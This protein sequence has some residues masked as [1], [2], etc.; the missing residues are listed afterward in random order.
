V[1][2]TPAIDS[3]P[4]RPAGD[5]IEP[6]PTPERI[7]EAARRV[8]ADPAARDAWAACRA[9]EEPDPR[10]LYALLGARRL[11]APAW[12]VAYGGRG[13]TAHHQAAVVDVLVEAGVPETLHTLSVQIAGTFLLGAGS[14]AQRATLLPGLAAGRSFCTVLY[15]EPDVGSDLAALTTTAEREPGGGWRLSGRKVYSVKTG[16]ADL[17][18][19]AARTPGGASRYQGITL[20]C[21]PLAT[22]GVTVGRLPSIGDE[23]FADVMF[24]GAVVPDGCVV[25]PVGEAWPLITDALALERTGVDYHAKARRWLALWRA[26]APAAGPP[27]AGAATS[28]RP[29]PS[30]V[31][32]AARLESRVRAAQLFATGCLDQMAAG[33]VDPVFAALTKLWCAETATSPGSAPRRPPPRC[34]RTRTPPSARRPA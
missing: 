4:R 34:R 16:L 26:G 7:G 27:A 12:P 20:F 21:V 5:G 2:A 29:E 25:G 13:L 8:L 33:R 15:S 1:T 32:D 9:G 22:P 3:G 31:V 18:L 10:P 19:V 11:L 28:P 17:G 24:D 30:A 14:R 23:H 6:D